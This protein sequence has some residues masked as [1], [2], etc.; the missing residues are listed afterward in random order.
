MNRLNAT[1][2]LLLAALVASG[3]GEAEGRGPKVGASTKVITRTW[4][5]SQIRH[6]R[7]AEVDG[8][9]S[10]EASP[11]NEVSMVATAEGDLELKPGK[12]NDGLFVTQLE[13]DT[14]SIGRNQRSRKKFRIPVLFGGDDVTISYVLR[15]PPTVSLGI[16]TV[17]GRIATR[18][19]NGETEAVTVNG[20]IDVETSGRG[21]LNATSVNGPVRVKFLESFQ[22]A[23]FKTVN[24]A[25][26][27]I[28]PQNASF[29][30][31]LSQVHGDFEAS[32]P[33]SIHSNPGSRRVSGEVNGGHYELK[34]VTVNGDVELTRLNGL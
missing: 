13:G 6:L 4:P 15:V 23:R 3:C 30:V 20:S 14:L 1:L 11:T 32:F 19:V 31:D 21:A 29:N 10:I 9:I 25:V 8:N 12:E 17:T 33:L 16:T 7:V 27:A 22:G 26:Q 28:L 34:I 2:F 18:G 5:A 24:G